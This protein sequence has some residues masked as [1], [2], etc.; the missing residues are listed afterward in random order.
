MIL[1]DSDNYGASGIEV[2]TFPGDRMPHAKVPI[3]DKEEQIVLHL[4]LRD[5]K[6]I[7]WAACVQS[8]LEAQRAFGYIPFVPY[9]P[10]RQ[11]KWKILDD[12]GELIGAGPKLPVI[13]SSIISTNYTFD[14]HSD[15]TLI[16]TGAQNFM[17][18]DLDLPVKTDVVGIIAP[19]EGATARAKDFR[20][21]F[22]PD[23]GIIQCTKVRDAKTG[24]LSH[25]AMQPLEH[26]GKHIIVDDI[27]DG[28]GTFNLLVEAFGQ[29]LLASDCSLEMFVSHGIFSKGLDAINPRIE[30]ITTTDSW[31]M[32]PNSERLTVIPLLPQ[33]L[34]RIQN[35]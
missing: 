12:G 26:R 33:L 22:Y 34:E 32:R 23:V 13:I 25:Y 19:D 3:F 5:W 4:K 15:Y 35:G 8:A 16:W 29:D 30:H 9:F 2:M 14:C 27:C 1:I 6:D 31:C 18:S 17:P 10:G 11:D 24:K 20:D 7:G 28:G 21:A